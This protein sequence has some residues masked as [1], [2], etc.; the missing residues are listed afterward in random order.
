MDREGS[1][2]NRFDDG[3]GLVGGDLG[4]TTGHANEPLMQLRPVMDVVRHPDPAR[5][6]DH[7]ETPT[8]PYTLR[9]RPDIDIVIV[10]ALRRAMISDL[11]SPDA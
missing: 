11:R 5:D 10:E 3:P 6:D 7:Q 8:Q 1:F 2:P 4:A 9:G